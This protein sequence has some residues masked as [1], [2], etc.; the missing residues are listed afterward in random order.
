MKQYQ[1]NKDGWWILRD[2]LLG[3]EPFTGPTGNFRGEQ[4]HASHSF[5]LT[6]AK[7]VGHMDESERLIM[8]ADA[9]N[10]GVDY[11]VYSY[12]TPI[13]WRRSDGFW[14]VTDRGY[15]TSTKKHLA[16]LRPAVD[17]LNSARV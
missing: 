3:L 12:A 14:R 16:R 1:V 2:L 5:A 6:R 4:C 10:H 8:L 11:M 9:E 7:H 13:A 15:S 17:A